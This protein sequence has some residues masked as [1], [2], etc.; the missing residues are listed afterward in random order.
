MRRVTLPR[1]R[2]LETRERILAAARQVFAAKGFA[3]ATVDDVATSAGVSKGALYHH[4]HSKDDLFFALLG[5]RDAPALA[6]LAQKAQAADT[7]EEIIR[8]V[9][10]EWLAHYTSD[11]LFAALSL[12]F[13]LQATRDPRFRE[14]VTQFRSALRSMLQ[15]LI[16]AGQA[17]GAV[18]EEVDS[19][20]AAA[21]LFGLLDGV[22][23]ACCTERDAFDRPLV[24]DVAAAAQRIVAARDVAHVP[25][26]QSFLVRCVREAETA[27]SQS[28][29][30][31]GKEG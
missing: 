29:L 30:S 23:L 13:R 12:E 28:E 16:E 27:A 4:F 5:H 20:G 9:V 6:S 25:A 18:P 1:Q 15:G 17:D 24:E 7:F 19:A 22:A 14:R 2:S 31:Q 3:A 8:L 26:S 11:P 21:V 10:R